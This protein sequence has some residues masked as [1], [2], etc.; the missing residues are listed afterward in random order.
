[1]LLIVV[2]TRIVKPVLT[3]SAVEGD[4]V[5][6]S[7]VVDS[8]PRYTVTHRWFHNSS[9]ISIQSASTQAVTDD[10]SSLVL[11]SVSKADAGSYTCMVE[12]DGGQ[13]NSTGW[14]HVIGKSEVSCHPTCY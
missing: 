4:R 9:L 3:V 8:D 12:S 13:D 5:T 2:R 11:Q 14:L 6:L 1:M 7:C 10:D